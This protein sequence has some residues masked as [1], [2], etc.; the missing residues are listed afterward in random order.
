MDE[1][2]DQEKTIRKQ[3]PANVKCIICRYWGDVDG[4]DKISDGKYI[5]RGCKE[6]E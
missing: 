4:H 5:C 3:K 2:I 6:K 1:T